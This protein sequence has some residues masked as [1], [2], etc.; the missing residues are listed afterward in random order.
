MYHQA[1]LFIDVPTPVPL[2]TRCFFF[3]SNSSHLGLEHSLKLAAV[4]RG[5]PSFFRLPVI[6]VA[7]RQR[8][9]EDAAVVQKIRQL[10]RIL[11]HTV[12]ASRREHTSLAPT[13]A[14][15]GKRWFASKADAPG[16][17]NMELTQEKHLALAEV[18]QA[19]YDR[20]KNFSFTEDMAKDK[21]LFQMFMVTRYSSRYSVWICGKGHLVST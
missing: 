16:K 2:L 11:W 13:V 18:R 7:P 20:L 12:L 17:G 10:K 5:F 8:V 19:M 3:L 15:K 21:S 6:A 4:L 1:I 14:R 9:K